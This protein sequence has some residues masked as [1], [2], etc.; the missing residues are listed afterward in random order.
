[1]PKKPLIKYTSRDFETIKA[2][3]VEHAKRYY[4]NSYNDFS[5]SSFGGMVMDSVAYVGDILS[6]YLDFQTNESFLETSLDLNNIRRLASQ[7]GYNYYGN[8]S[9][10][11]IGTFYVLVPAA[12][13]G[14]GVDTT[15]VPIIKTGTKVRSSSATFTLTENIDFNDPTVEVVAARF[16]ETTGKPTQYAL[17]SFGQ[18]KSG[19]EF[20]NEIEVGE[21][22]KFL[23][24]RVST[25]AVNEIISVFDTEGHQYYQVDN[26]SQEVVYL[27]QSNPNVKADG[28][29]SILKPFI[30]SR[31][32]VVEQDQTGTYLQ[33]GYGSETQIDQFGIADPSQVVLKMNGKNYVT[34]TAFDP[35][36]FLGTDKFGIAPE[37]TTLRVVFGSNDS[38][39]VNVPINGLI[40]VS[41]LK[42]EFPNDLTNPNSS[43]QIGVRISAEVT[44]DSLI[45]VERAIPTPEEI[46]YRAYAVYS[47]QNRVVTK[48]DYEAYCYQMP[49]KFGKIS[50][51]NV[52]ND[53]SGINKR[54]AM[55]VISKNN[56]ENFVATND[57]IKRNLKTWLNKNK[58]MTDQID[59]FDARI[60]NI[61]FNFKYTT[62]SG[63]SK[64]EVQTAVN[65][66]VANMF[67][68]KLYIGEP[69]YVTK[70][71]Q[72]I[73][74]VQGVVDTLKVT[75]L[76]KQS[77]NYS[78]LGL[79]IDD[80]L[81]K[82]GTFLKCPKN[83]V[84]EIKFPSQDLK[85]TII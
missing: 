4:P 13:T 43:K 47:A 84:F 76:I 6:F 30:A 7:M 38:V 72:T 16:D 17:R 79:E 81:S 60:I 80:I 59:V 29:R 32:F 66:A 48:N 5:D 85:G 67:T 52:V 9:S 10:Y 61:G 44:N 35:N 24:V 55:Y 74:R 64:T 73:N 68:E 71:Y 18:V 57:T 37:N 25:A 28:V 15:Y 8:P 21:Q 20:Y 82:D 3:L 56:N 69:V 77:A 23:K 22:V 49:R 45:T 14:L 26:L 12:P 65:R 70:L 33:F 27:E 51:I 1:M 54:L 53:P 41:N 83:C 34:D 42:M 36:Q 58:M 78:N 75:P 63:F 40:E 19:V 46:K 31:R 62:E 50:R 2:D 11:G 39:D